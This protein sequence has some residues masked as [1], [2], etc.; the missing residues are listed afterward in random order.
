MLKVENNRYVLNI[1]KI[2]L[3]IIFNIDVS[4]ELYMNNHK[5]QVVINT[6]KV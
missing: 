4:N 2:D 6:P 5:L 1:K 3:K